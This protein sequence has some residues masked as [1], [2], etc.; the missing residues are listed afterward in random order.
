MHIQYDQCTTQPVLEIHMK[1]LYCTINCHV[2]ACNGHYLQLTAM[3]H[4]CLKEK[5]LLKTEVL[6]HKLPRLQAGWCLQVHPVCVDCLY[7][8]CVVFHTS[9]QILAAC[10][11]SAEQAGHNGNFKFWQ[12][13][14]H[15]VYNV[16]NKYQYMRSEV[17]TLVTVRITIFEHMTLCPLLETDKHFEGT[18]C[19]Q[20]QSR[21]AGSSF[22]QNVGKSVPKHMAWHHITEEGTSQK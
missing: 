18:S 8:P 1:S 9:M 6:V 19:L 10:I 15:I 5:K 2:K 4:T 7:W 13:T 14:W 11:R 22:L 3:I 17:P 16:Q 20:F 12:Y 21:I